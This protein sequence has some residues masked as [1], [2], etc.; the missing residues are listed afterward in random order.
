MQAIYRQDSNLRLAPV[1][2]A[3]VH[4]YGLYEMET[5]G[6]HRRCDT[7]KNL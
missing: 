2:A 4:F 3:N 5:Y 6:L 7:K 1:V